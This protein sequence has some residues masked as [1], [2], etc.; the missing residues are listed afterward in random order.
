V[1][2]CVVIGAGTNELVAAH[3][4]ARAGHRVVVLDEHAFAGPPPGDAGWLPPR[5]AR[6]LALQRHGWAPERP[7]PWLTIALQGGGRLELARDVVRAADAIR[8]LSPRD[9]ERWPAF[10]ERMA[11][12]A[13]LLARIYDAP[14]PDPLARDFSNLAALVALGARARRLGREDLYELM[15]LVPM[16]VA[17]WL[18]EWFECDALKGALAA[19]GVRNLQQ[20]PRSGGTAFSLLHHHAGQDAGVFFPQHSNAREVLRALPGI[21]L[22]ERVKV[23]RLIV[24]GGRASGVGLEDGSELAADVVLSGAPVERTLLA[25]T[26]PG[27]F[28]PQ[29]V[30]AVRCVRARG[31]SFACTIA[32]DREPGFS[33]FALIASVEE[34]ER[35]YDDA[36]YGRVSSVPYVEAVARAADADARPRIELHVQ[37]APYALR[38]GAWDPAR[39]S[40]LTR[41]ATGLLAAHDPALRDAVV[42][43]V[44]TPLDLE[45]LYGWPQG[46]VQHAELALD[47]LLWARPVPELARYRTPLPGL[48]V[49]GAD[50][51]PGAGVAGAAG[52]HAARIVARD[53]KRGKES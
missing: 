53:L 33:R 15:R 7:D 52:A 39:G 42:E 12:L 26:D 46:Q 13:G 1:S 30:H 31:V 22:R 36:K 40:R 38:Q 35:A 10:C 11:R 24:R 8:R 44:W 6:D 51:H 37:Y 9:G 2:A 29:L 17:D 45:R 25:L 49:C 20:G 19:A 23:A 4:L 27:W 3:Y 14:P 41:Q 48:Y 21:E 18:D 34:L 16:S 32:L 50:M 5:I 43:R 28:D 47:Q